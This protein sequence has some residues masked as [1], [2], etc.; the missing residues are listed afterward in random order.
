MTRVK[1]SWTR[2]EEAPPALGPPPWVPGCGEEAGSLPRA[3]LGGAR[4]AAACACA[5]MGPQAGRRLLFEPE[6]ICQNAVTLRAGGGCFLVLARGLVSWGRWECRGRAPP[7]KWLEGAWGVTTGLVLLC[8]KTA[9]LVCAAPG[10]RREGNPR[11]PPPPPSKLR[12]APVG[13]KTNKQTNPPRPP[14]ETPT[15]FAAFSDASFLLNLVLAG[16]SP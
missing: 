10:L 3:R 4:L 7:L 8:K 1:H 12:F 5:H 11:G 9:S 13:D 15:P 2:A 14:K 6:C 16:A